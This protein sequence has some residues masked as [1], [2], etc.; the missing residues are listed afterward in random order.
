MKPAAS[1]SSEQRVKSHWEV[2]CRLKTIK[3]ISKGKWVVLLSC[4]GQCYKGFLWGISSCSL[5]N[6]FVFGS[7]TS[8][9]LRQTPVK[10]SALWGGAND[11]LIQVTCKC[12]QMKLGLDNVQLVTEKRFAG[13]VLVLKNAKINEN[14]LS[15]SLVWTTLNV[16]FIATVY[17]WSQMPQSKQLVSHW[18]IWLTIKPVF[19]HWC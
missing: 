16:P 5:F 1:K 2:Y 14:D 4:F 9:G 8:C 12:S 10:R 19:S 15:L 7:S 3:E 18:L 11:N 17:D 6:H 13:L